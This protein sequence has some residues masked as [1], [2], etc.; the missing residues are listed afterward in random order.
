MKKKLKITVLVIF[1]AV[2]WALI[3]SVAYAQNDK[4]NILVIWGDDVGIT[5]VPTVTV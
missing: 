5:S 3:G 4:P 1:A 2:A